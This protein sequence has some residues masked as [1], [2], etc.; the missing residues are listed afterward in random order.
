MSGF[1]SPVFMNIFQDV[2][3]LG[4]IRGAI[5]AE[6]VWPV[7]I[8]DCRRGLFLF[9]AADV[10][11]ETQQQCLLKQLASPVGAEDCD[12]CCV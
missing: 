1:D 8:C 3:E 9:L 2:C 10:Y 5:L 6:D 4:G 11:L 12:G 7:E